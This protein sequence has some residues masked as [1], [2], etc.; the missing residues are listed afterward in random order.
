MLRVNPGTSLVLA[1]NQRKCQ[2]L[3]IHI[4][5]IFKEKRFTV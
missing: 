4:P 3:R 1:R 2:K 5:P